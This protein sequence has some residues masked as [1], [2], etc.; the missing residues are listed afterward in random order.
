MSDAQ[1]R[2]GAFG[3]ATYR[4][5]VVVNKFNTHENYHHPSTICAVLGEFRHLFVLLKSEKLNVQTL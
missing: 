1:A 2:R 5:V 3:D 4:R